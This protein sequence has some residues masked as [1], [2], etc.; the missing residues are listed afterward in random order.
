MKYDNRM[1]YFKC[2]EELYYLIMGIQ[3]TRMLQKRTRTKI[4][5]SLQTKFTPGY[6]Q[7]TVLVTVNSAMPVVV[8]PHW[9]TLSENRKHFRNRI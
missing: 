7:C 5:N 2:L 4:K 3:S 6:L 8:Q 1:L 9:Q